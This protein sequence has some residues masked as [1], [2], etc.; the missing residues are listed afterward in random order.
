MS[1]ADCF[2]GP[3]SSRA[4][5]GRNASRDSPCNEGARQIAVDAW[6]ERVRG[7]SMVAT[8]VKSSVAR[9]RR[10]RCRRSFWS[11]RNWTLSLRLAVSAHLPFDIYS[12]RTDPHVLLVYAISVSSLMGIPCL[13]CSTYNYSDITKPDPYI[14]PIHQLLIKHAPLQL[15]FRLRGERS[16]RILEASVGCLRRR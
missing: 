3:R 14:H 4:S 7:I 5:S 9:S 10:S 15:G 13:W 12:C 11:P 1:R 8:R 2:T 16:T 6:C